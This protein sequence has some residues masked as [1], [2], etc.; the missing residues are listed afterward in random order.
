MLLA[1]GEECA[2]AVLGSGLGVTFVPIR[3]SGEGSK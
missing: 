2:E 1:Y 3:G